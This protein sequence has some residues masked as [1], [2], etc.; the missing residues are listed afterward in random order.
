MV[1]QLVM[2]LLY[3]MIL[4]YLNLFPENGLPFFIDLLSSN[5]L[6]QSLIKML[7]QPF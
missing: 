6:I 3:R 4:F 7:Q 5:F 2:L 1:L